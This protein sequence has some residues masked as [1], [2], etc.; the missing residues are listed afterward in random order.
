M[1]AAGPRGWLGAWFDWY[2]TLPRPGRLAFWATGGG[3]ALDA[4]NQMSVSFILTPLTA[5]FTLS[6]PQAGLIA[7]IG[8]VTSAIGGALTGALADH[9][10]R[11]RVLLIS[12]VSYALFTFLAGCAQS[13]EQLLLFVTLQ[14]LGFGG[15]WAAGAVLVAEYA[16]PSQRGRVVGAVQSAWAIGYAGVLVANT[17]I[18]NLVP[19][20]IGW[21]LMFWVGAGP[22]VLLLWV[23]SHLQE[24]PAYLAEE[25]AAA[26]AAR[27]RRGAGF[28]LAGLLA[29]GQRRVTFASALLSVGV[30]GAGLAVWL[31]TY[32]QQVRH[33]SVDAIGAYMGVMTAGGFVGCLCAGYVLDRLGRRPG[34]ALFALGSMLSAWTYVLLPL[35]ASG[36]AFAIGFPMGFFGSGIF[37]GL[38]A[39]LSELYPTELRGAGQGFGYNFGRGVA[40]LGP[41]GIG[42]V[43]A[44]GGLTLG[45]ALA[46]ST[47]SLCLVGLLFLPETRGRVLTT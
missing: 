34:M 36:L 14:G 10:G 41:T 9:I 4:F 18:F 47:Y 19:P 35:E 37:S 3:W 25:T 13:Y 11:V 22:A 15:E 26:K 2:W 24:S 33:L 40:A 5:A 43:A 32:L 21:R 16:R 42:F 28:S 29:P 39:Y 20:E 7:T 30:I 6:D 44:Q 31:P 1:A 27:A 17:V 46:A 12:I 45:L 23:R 38:A 8:G